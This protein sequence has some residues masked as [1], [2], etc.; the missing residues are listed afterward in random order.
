MTARISELLRLSNKKRRSYNEHWR[1]VKLRRRMLKNATVCSIGPDGDPRPHA[2][3]RIN[4]VEMVGL[5]DSGA[6]IS[7]LGEGAEDALSRCGLQ[8]KRYVGKPVET[9]GGHA[10]TIVGFVDAVVELRE[11]KQRIRFFVV[12]SLTGNLYLG[13]DVWQAFDLLPKL[14][15][16]VLAEGDVEEEKPDTHPL[17]ATQRARLDRIVAIFP[18][19]TKEGLGK[20]SL[21]RHT[22][23]VGDAKPVKHRY[24]AVSPAVERDMHAEVDRMISLGVI[25][26]SNSP[27]SSPMTVVAKSNGKV[28]MCLDAR[29]VNAVTR[30]DAYPTP[31]IDGI[32]SRLNETRYITS[33]DLK[34]AYWQIELDEKSRDKT[35]FTIP[36]RPLYHFTRMPFGLC[37]ASQTMCRLMDRV[38][39]SVLRD[40][41]FVYIDDLLVVS[42]DFDTHMER[43]EQVAQSMRRAN[44]TIN[45]DKSKFVMKSLRYLGYIIGDGSIRVDPDKVQCVRE[46]PQPKT[47]RQV[48]RFLGM[49]GWY[50]RF[51]H[52]YASIAAP[53][54]DLLKKSD[55]F[56]WTAEAQGAFELLKDRM[57]S[58]PVLVHPDFSQRFFIQCDACLTGVGGVLYQ[59][60]NG[61]EHPIAFMSRKLNAAQQNYNV[62]EL[63]CLAAIMCVEKFRGYVEGM[64]FTIITDHA[65]LKW[66]MSQKELTGR[67]ARWSLKLQGFDFEIEHRKG[68]ANVVP[69]TLSRM[70][71]AS[72][73]TVAPAPIDL[74]SVEFQGDEYAEMRASVT[75]N[76]DQHPDVEVRG[77]V[78][79]KRT[80]FR[81][82]DAVID[83]ETMWKV[84]VP[85]ALRHSAIENAHSPPSAS[86]GGTDKTIDLVC[87]CYYWPGLARDVR[88]FVAS[89]ETC[90]QT[91]APNQTL[92]PPMGKPFVVERPFQHLYV[93]L[94]G[95][96]PRSKAGNTTILIVLDQLTKFVWLKA[97]RRATASSIV[98]Y[99]EDDVFH[100][101]GVP[102]SILTD[103]GIQFVSKEWKAMLSR[104]DSRHVL[105]ASHSPQANASER[106]N[107]SILA[108]I[109]AYI[110]SDQTYWDVHLSVIA[111]ALR[112]ARHST[113][114]Q[115]PYFAV[116]GQHMIQHA[117]AYKLLRALQAL[118]TGDVEIVSGAE[119][120]DALHE[121][122]RERLQK[123]N[124][125]NAKTYNTR[126]KNVTFRPGQEVFIR[127]FAQSDAAQNFNAKLGRQWV[128]ARI[129]G[130]K[131]T[132]VYVVEKPDGT[133]IKVTYHAKDIRA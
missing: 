98:Q 56:M 117:G 81:T 102:E 111:S 106:V 25:E 12:P 44:L 87:R 22:I 57:T 77:A 50:H 127:N 79:Y 21:I 75:A 17:D 114:G 8:M 7:C 104:Y 105:T 28:R 46:F 18:S 48:R 60:V 76:K 27:W 64:P 132:N 115:S 103:N 37:N 68:S 101:F 23:D 71:V 11:R 95:P 39:P 14:E 35:A 52:N 92:R 24:H 19:S 97:L 26:E 126:A 109:R 34:D 42:E 51:I 53:I 65:S 74:Q 61:E 133:K 84:W 108:S 47:V 112:N 55:R 10:H 32:L 49:T 69:D 41:V 96:Y 119:H 43:L 13:I 89:C 113:T 78:M 63:E 30:K 20:T 94:L 73:H 110:E 3:V 72:L 88:K 130:N 80:G 67:L 93:D 99:I 123:A 70:H 16:V 2:T 33:I 38:V 122:M 6:S 54:T 131:G 82:G 107:R 58:A 29:Q 85:T 66:L 128:P 1:L 4:G 124:D 91:K 45:V 15:E 9:A 5:L 125:R 40:V 100:L 36:G 62:S 118:G 86:H 116:Y 59:L 121:A 129:A 31:L 83:S 120:R 90:K